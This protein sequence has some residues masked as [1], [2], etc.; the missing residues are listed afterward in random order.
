MRSILLTLAAVQLSSA[1]LSVRATSAEAPLDFDPTLAPV[2]G[3]VE[4]YQAV[5]GN[6]NRYFRLDT[7]VADL[8]SRQRFFESW[9]QRLA[10]IDFEPLDLEGRIDFLM[11]GDLLR[12][13]LQELA[14]QRARLEEITPLL[15]FNELILGL[16]VA[17]REV[18]PLDPREAA[19]QLMEVIHQI[20]ARRQELEQAAEK[21]SGKPSGWD[22]TVAYRAARAVT[23]LS[24]TLSEWHEFYDS[25]DPLF[26]WWMKEPFAAVME[27]LDAYA[28]YIRK[29]LAGI[30]EEESDPVIGDPIGRDA[31]QNA[32]ARERI[33]YSPEEL[34]EIARKEMAWCDREMKVASREMGLGEDWRRALQQVKD[35]HV[36]PGEQPQLIKKLALETEAF[37]D[38]RDLVTIPQQCRDT[39][40][41]QMMSPE[42]QKVTPYFTG[43]EVISVSFPTAEMKHDD[44]L[45]SLRSN[46][47]HF[48]R[49]TVHHEVIPGHHRETKGRQPLLGGVAV[50]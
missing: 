27:K 37:L 18:N 31:L 20:D 1:L 3:L 43:G 42:Y 15:P 34:I 13:E 9:E 41:M 49:A 47:E 25:Y 32:L 36:G 30:Q 44:K 14:Q 33:D 45:M 19:G 22:P 39:W 10:A 40:R 24:R 17:R 50:L 38:A 11:F 7:S 23:S 2:R 28:G 48:S 26:S 35:H 16:A 21:A 12:F 8:E 4:R 46:N 6:L 5:M 29:E